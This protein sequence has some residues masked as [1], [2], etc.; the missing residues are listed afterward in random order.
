M[1]DIFE[2]KAKIWNSRLKQCLKEKQY[3]QI[4]F[5]DKLNEQFEMS[6]TQE[7][8]SRWLHVGDKKSKRDK[9]GK[10]FIG[11]PNYENMICIAK[12]L[13]V[14]LGY[15]TGETDAE[16]FTLEQASELLNL[17]TEALKS[18]IKLTQTTNSNVIIGRKPEKYRAILNN[19]FT[20]NSFLRI[21]DLLVDLSDF[22]NLYI[23]LDKEQ[24]KLNLK[25]ELGNNLFE[26]AAKYWDV[27]EF[28]EVAVEL[29]SEEWDAIHKF[30][31]VI[32]KMAM[33]DNMKEP[34]AFERF[35][36]QEM[37]TLLLNELYPDKE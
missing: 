23:K 15:L 35:K 30:N 29:S 1:N 25:N 8:V 34:M 14:D 36:V 24:L 28:D 32:D 9:N 33:I 26:K 4:G 10:E 13:D 19:L 6:V 18:I 22:Y 37:F 21:L 7:T 27:T 17:D 3:T 11:F 2:E 12:C 16:T 5:A 20:S 31:D